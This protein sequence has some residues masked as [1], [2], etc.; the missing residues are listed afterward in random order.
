MSLPWNEIR[1]ALDSEP[2]VRLS[3]RVIRV[4]GLVLQGLMPGAKM[5]MM[6][7]LHIPGAAESV[8]AEVVQAARRREF[9]AIQCHKFMLDVLSLR[10]V[11]EYDASCAVDRGSEGGDGEFFCM[12]FLEDDSDEVP[13]DFTFV[14]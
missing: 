3:G 14:F 10:R 8:P 13:F 6:C 7:R 11:Q 12:E 4:G 1:A 2:P 9:V 5:G